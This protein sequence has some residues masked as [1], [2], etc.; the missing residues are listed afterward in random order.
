MADA[1]SIV[2]LGTAFAAGLLS[3]FSPCVM[4]LMP[5]YLS[6]VSGLSVEEMQE[7]SSEPVVRRRVLAGSLGFVA[8]FSTVFVILG[9]SATVLGHVL[10]TWS[11]RVL[12]V[13]F[14][15]PQIA[16]V[17]IIVMGLHIAGILP[18]HMLYRER[19]VNL[20]V[21]RMNPVGT[22]LVGAAFAFGWSPCVGPI[23]GGILTIAGSRET[24]IQGVGLLAVYSAG[25]GVPFLVAAWSIDLFFH[26]FQRVKT[27]FRML[28]LLSGAL[29]VGVG[30][31]VM[32]DQL[33]RLNGYFMF[34]SRFVTHTE[35]LLQ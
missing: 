33:A 34:M 5:A 32:T 21:R 2:S 25:L 29:L 14:G 7:G 26:A 16:G 35:R 30:F 12:G 8:G 9:A 17:V 28:E 6:L 27:H 13:E 11:V 24:V 23:L 18:V 1:T 22:Y 15:V 4:P 19:R 3:V 10:R 20:Q 31:L